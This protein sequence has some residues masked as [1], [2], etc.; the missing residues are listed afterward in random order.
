MTVPPFF[1]DHDNR[2]SNDPDAWVSLVRQHLSAA[3]EQVASILLSDGDPVE[4][5]VRIE[6]HAVH[7]EA[8]VVE[9]HGHTP[10]RYGEHVASFPLGNMHE[11]LLGE[12]LAAAIAKAR[13]RRLRRFRTCR[14]C[15]TRN[16]PEWMHATDVCQACAERELGIVY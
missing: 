9:W 6:P 13:R 1:A 8:P 12:P 15:Q 5:L 7:V 11:T 3:Q 14:F 16:P 4:V 2:L 10:V